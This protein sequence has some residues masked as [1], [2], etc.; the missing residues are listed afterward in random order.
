MKGVMAIVLAG[1]RGERLHP[2]TQ[3]RAKPAVPFGGIYRIIDFTLSNCLNSNLRKIY[4]LTQYKSMS[5]DRHLR[6]GWNVFHPHLNEDLC[7]IPPQQRNSSH[8]YEGTA[9]AIFQNIYTIEAE[10]PSHVIVLAGDHVYKMNYQKMI[11]YH[12][13]NNADATV[14]ALEFDIEK[15]HEFGVMQVN[16]AH[17]VLG[18]QEKPEHP[19]SLPENPAKALISM[20]IYVFKTDVLI[21]A[22]CEDAQK[23]TKHDFGKNIIPAL[24]KSHRVFAY[25]FVDENKKEDEYWRDIGTLDA[26]WEANMDLVSV[27][28]HLNLYDTEW[29]IRTYQ[30]QHPPAKT[31]F[32]QERPGGRI[33]LVLDSIISAGCII[34]G[35]RVERCVLSP[36]VRINSYCSVKDSILMEGVSIG[37]HCRI[38]KA[39]IDKGVH[40]PENM[41][42]GFNPEEDRKH[43]TLSPSGVVVIPKGT[44]LEK[45]RP[46]VI[47]RNVVTKR[48]SFGD[49]V[50]SSLRSSQ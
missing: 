49:E 2:L 28:P 44:H 35:G 43:F 45:E 33:G 27:H 42:I 26:Y 30:E 6:L 50:A 32:A 1:G 4:V 41:V 13:E 29:P 36:G 10:R 39:I 34:S 31:V 47:A 38:Q 5:L 8:W 15:T 14:G 46:L 37:R 20:G 22:L 16:A 12:L 23:D 19:I 17:R 9:D 18:F 11:Q 3:D 21:A 25:P 24:V 40:V 48:S 7:I